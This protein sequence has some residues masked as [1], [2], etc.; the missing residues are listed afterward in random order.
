[1]K[2]KAATLVAMFTL[3]NSA[4]LTAMDVVRYERGQS[5]LDQRV[6][7]K[8]E[9]L[10]AALEQTIDTHGPYQL[11]TN[12]PRMNSMQAM[13][14]LQTG[15]E[16][17]NTFIALTNP[18]WEANTI[19]IRIPIR[20]G[21]LSYRLLLVHQNDLELFK[22]VNTLSDLRQL[23]V[24]LRHNWSLTKSMRAM[25][26]TIV[27]A[28]SYDGLFMMLERHRFNYIPRGIN[29]V[30]GE[31]E[32]R[33]DDLPNVRVEPRIALHIPSPTYIFVSPAYPQ[34]AKRLEEGLERMIANGSLE[35]LFQKHFADDIKRADLN[36]RHIIEVGNPLLPE[37]TPL[38]RKEL[39][40]DPLAN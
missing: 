23:T 37:K 22:R 15:G 39:W 9:V 38:Q 11:T 16:V 21:I 8:R 17:L 26:F 35:A 30:F 36:N 4:P 3:I 7:Y 34:L 20:R 25:Q 6:N 31:Y 10:K 12:A 28:S 2:I 19:P 14:Q 27:P 24:G 5:Q 13:R 1:M 29:E 18:E 40:F 33:K 32:S